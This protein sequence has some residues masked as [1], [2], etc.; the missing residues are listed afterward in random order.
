MH[1]ENPCDVD[2]GIDSLENML[3][4]ANMSM[5]YK[6]KQASKMSMRFFQRNFVTLTTKLSLN[7]F[8]KEL[9]EKNLL[10]VYNYESLLQQSRI[11]QNETF[12]LNM[13]VFGQQV[14]DMFLEWLKTNHRDIFESTQKVPDTHESVI[15]KPN[16]LNRLSLNSMSI[17]DCLNARVI[18]SCLYQAGHLTGDDLEIILNATTRRKQCTELMSRVRR[19]TLHPEF[20]KNFETI[21]QTWQPFLYDTLVLETFEQI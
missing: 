11:E 19:K 1:L 5:L 4:L 10:P 15:T 21:L 16:K 6:Q 9:Y 13:C 17:N 20:F 18:A 3:K 12:L 2:K 14:M 8:L 7:Q